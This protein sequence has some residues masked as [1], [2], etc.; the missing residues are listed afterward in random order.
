VKYRNYKSDG[1]TLIELM[2]VIAIVAILVTLAVPAY[3][4]FT[5]RAKVTECISATA[6]PKIQI[7][8]YYQTMGRWPLTASEAGIEESLPKVSSFCRMMFYNEGLGDY[9]IMID[10]AAL[11]AHVASIDI[12][13]VM[14]P[15]EEATGAVNWRCTRGTTAVDGLKYLPSSCRGPNI[16]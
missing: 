16:F 10:S 2:I 9:A 15:I 13:P 7:S 3:Q 8:E 12:L 11:G 1:F 14:S 6:P 4:D 5:I